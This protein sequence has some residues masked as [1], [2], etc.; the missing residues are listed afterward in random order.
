MN[1]GHTLGEIRSRGVEKYVKTNISGIGKSEGGREKKERKKRERACGRDGGEREG[2]NSFV[3]S[4]GLYQARYPEPLIRLLTA[5]WT[6]CKDELE[7]AI[8]S[9]WDPT[10]LSLFSSSSGF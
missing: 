9:L 8:P 10:A 6:E 5:R 3:I 4:V 2:T 1:E 7:K